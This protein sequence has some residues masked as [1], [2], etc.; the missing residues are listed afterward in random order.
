MATPISVGVPPLRE[1]QTIKAWRPLFEAAVSTLTQSED[2]QRAAIRLLPAYVSRGELERKVVLKALEKQSLEEAFVYLIEHLDP[3]VDEFAATERFREMTWPPGE[4]I[5]DFLARYLEEGTMA[6]LDPKQVCRFLITQLPQEAQPKLKEWLSQQAAD[7]SEDGALKMAA[8]IRKSLV[9]K[10]IPL[11]K[12]WRGTLSEKVHWTKQ[13][14]GVFPDERGIAPS[15]GEEDV[16]YA[17][18]QA[19]PEAGKKTSGRSEPKCFNCGKLGHFIRACP[20]QRKCSYCGRWGHSTAVCRSKGRD[21]STAKVTSGR[22]NVYTVA[23]SEEAVTLKVLIEGQEVY[24]IL[25]TGATPCILDKVT[26]DNLGL[27]RTMIRR[28]SKVYGVNNPVP[29]LGYAQASISV[30]SHEPVIQKVQ[31]LDSEEPTILLGRQLMR[32][33][34]TI[35]FDLLNGRIK[36][37]NTWES[38]KATVRGATPLAR[39]QVAKQEETLDTMTHEGYRLLVNPELPEVE[40]KQLEELAK[41]FEHA[42][43]QDHKKPSRTTSS[44]Q[45]AIITG[46][47]QPQKSRPRRVPPKW[48]EEINKQLTEMLATEPPIIRPS[49]SPWASDVVLV[50]RKMAAF[51]SQWIIVG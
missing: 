2:G 5:M 17:T 12:G 39:A 31:V 27:S 38:Y 13:P 10:G 47:A 16:V 4:M 22:E 37:G 7:L 36:I 19:R 30:G 42:F 3:E 29:V 49:S 35:S 21:E 32:Q 45:Q 41:Q 18:R 8:E 43:A 33:L 11:D 34:G 40:R 14:S 1:R 50:K 44:A 20:H 46:D 23:S 48:E 26:A 9:N 25:D 15:S 6:R 51:V 28:R 24:A